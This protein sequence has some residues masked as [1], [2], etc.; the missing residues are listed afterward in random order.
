MI[1]L[2]VSPAQ[3][4]LAK[5]LEA[6]KR[7]QDTGK[8]VFRSADFSRLEREA[9]TKNG[10]LRQIIKSW[11]MATRPDERAGDTTPW[12]AIITDFIREYCND[13]FGDTWHASPEYSI[14][15]H[16]GNTI[17][18]QQIVIYSP[19]AQNTLLDLPGGTSLLDYKRRDELASSSR[20][21]MIAGIRV[22]PLSLA[23]IRT[24]EAF[25]RNYSRDAQIALHKIDSSELIRDLVEGGHSVLAGRLTGALRAIRR[26]DF[27]DEIAS[28]LKSAGYSVAETNPF[29][30]PPPELHF[31]RSQSP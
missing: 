24:S 4:Q 18:P 2:K 15:L 1:T 10:F 26:E 30:N 21:E 11:Y 27:A 31:E 14:L 22:M 13:R 20:I 28:T 19:N 23:L 5:A 9:L 8:T 7:L 12:Y 16:V 29:L 6:L 17:A 3:R 25:F